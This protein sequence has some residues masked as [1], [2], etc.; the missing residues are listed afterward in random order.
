MVILWMSYLKSN[1]ANTQLILYENKQRTK[2]GIQTEE[3]DN[4]C[5]SN[6]Q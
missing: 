4:G 6:T 2:T 5:F 1:C 3:A